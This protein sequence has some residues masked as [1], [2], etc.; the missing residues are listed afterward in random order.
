[1][2]VFRLTVRLVLFA[3]LAS[4]AH[5]QSESHNNAETIYRLNDNATYQEGC[6]DPCRCQIGAESTVR[7]TFKLGPAIPGNVVDFREVTEVYWTATFAGDPIHT[8]SGNGVYR[9]TNFDSEPQHSLDLDLSI[10]GAPSQH[11]FSDFVPASSK[12]GGINLPVS[13][14]GVYCYDIV[15]GVSAAP[16]PPEELTSYTLVPGSTFQ[17]A[18]FD[19]CDC[20]SQEPRPMFGD[21]QLVPLIDFGTYSEYAIVDVLLGVQSLAN[22]Q[23]LLALTGSGHY[24]LIQGFAGPAHATQISLSIN[25]EA[26][27]RFDQELENTSTGF[28]AIDIVVDMNDME[29]TDTVLTIKARPLRDS[30]IGLRR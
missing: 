11:F 9:I 12:D 13:I 8:I 2:I 25:G 22:A 21:F 27:I 23:A 20:V 4:A 1:M 7:G 5:A 30:A 26:P 15:I 16:V 17:I 18:C 14:N 10:D 19:P 3:L 6:F 29:C 24:T 28:P